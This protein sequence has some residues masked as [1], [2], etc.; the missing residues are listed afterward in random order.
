[1][2]RLDRRLT[3]ATLAGVLLLALSACAG[4]PELEELHARV[5][6]SAPLEIG[7]DAELRV[8]LEGPTNG[9]RQT[10]A[11][12]RYSRIGSGP[13]EVVLRYDVRALASS[14]EYLLRAELRDEGR[15]THVNREPVT[16]TGAQA[17]SS[18]IFEIPLEPRLP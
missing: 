7:S 11:E 2:R 16:L 5:V 18:R 1:M 17:T 15:I 14:S 6:P 4:R 8:S 3:F 9:Q 12:S 10:I 13:I